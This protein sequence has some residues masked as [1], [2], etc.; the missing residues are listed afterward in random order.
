MFGFFTGFSDNLPGDHGQLVDLAQNSETDRLIQKT[1]CV[2]GQ[3]VCEKVK[4]KT[5]LFLGA[6]PIFFGKGVQG[7]MMDT[8]GAGLCDD[9]MRRVRAGSVAGASIQT[10][11]FRP[12]SVAIHDD[13]HMFG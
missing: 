12:P 5:D 13:G 9:V 7:Q 1:G 2:P 8:H 6:G 3:V 10:L 4:E 11:P